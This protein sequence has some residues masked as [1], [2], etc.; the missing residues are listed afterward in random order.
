[1]HKHLDWYNVALYS[2][3]ALGSL[4]LLVISAI[5]IPITWLR[6][7]AVIL[8][9]LIA[10][11]AIEEVLWEISLAKALE[12]KDSGKVDKLWEEKE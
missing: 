2:I 8:L 7:V 3:I 5:M 12:D 11:S 9:G 1:M 6:V 10:G 4:A